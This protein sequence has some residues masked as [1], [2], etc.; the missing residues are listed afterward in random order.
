M[1]KGW[2][3]ESGRERRKEKKRREKKSRRK[4]R[5][6]KKPYPSEPNE[7]ANLPPLLLNGQALAPS[8]GARVVPRPLARRPLVVKVRNLLELLVREKP[9]V[10]QRRGEGRVHLPAGELHQRRQRQRHLPEFGVER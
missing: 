8:D 1:S 3:G 9:K 10:E 7:L 4:K 2:L 6:T 5:K